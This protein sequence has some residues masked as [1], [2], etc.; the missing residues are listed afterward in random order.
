M[1][2]ERLEVGVFAENCYIIGCEKTHQGVVIDPGDEIP[3]ILHKIDE[4]QLDIKFILL[5]HAHL[6]HVKE[7]NLLKE[8]ITVPVMMHSADEFLLENLSSQA[9]AFGLSISGIPKVDKY[10]IEGDFIDFG[11]SRFEVLHTP[12]HSPGSVSYVSTG[13]AFVGDVLFAGSVGRTD[14][15]GGDYDMLINSIKTKVYP[16][17][18]DTTIYPGHGPETTLGRERQVNPFLVV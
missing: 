10:V 12:G 17:G 1:I 14:L 4:M 2:I 15:P 7:L 8:E 9:A 16:L 3:K 5:T 11:Q 6:D 18:D 13:V